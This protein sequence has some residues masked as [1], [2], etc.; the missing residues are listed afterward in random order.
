MDTQEENIKRTLFGSTDVVS[1]SLRW[2][3]GQNPKEKDILALKDLATGENIRIASFCSGCSSAF[4][5]PPL[6]AKAFAWNANVIGEEFENIDKS[7]QYMIT[8]LCVLC[9]DTGPKEKAKVH[10]VNY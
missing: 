9:S 3:G 7:K 2:I 8:S 4:G 1:L 6:L 10:F 5:Y